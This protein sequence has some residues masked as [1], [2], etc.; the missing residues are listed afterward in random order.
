MKDKFQEK[1]RDVEA[2]IEDY[3]QMLGWCVIIRSKSISKMS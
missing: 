2:F 3:W 1:E